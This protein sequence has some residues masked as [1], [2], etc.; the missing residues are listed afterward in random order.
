MQRKKEARPACGSG[1]GQKKTYSSTLIQGGACCKHIASRLYIKGFEP[2]PIAPGQK[3]PVSKNWP[4]MVLPVEPWPKNHGVGLRTGL[5][6]A[7]D[8]DIYH[9]GIID[10]LLTEQFTGLDYVTR[11]G[12]PPKILIPVVCPDLKCKIMSDRWIDEHGIINQIE[13]LSYGQQFVAFGIHPG[14]GKPY[15]WSDDFLKHTPPTVSLKFIGKLFALFKK[16]AK[17]SGWINVS[18][19]ARQDKNRPKSQTPSHGS[20]PGDIFNKA[21]TIEELLTVYGWKH[22]RGKWWTRPG[23][24]TGVSGTVANNTFYVFTSSTCLEPEKSY[25]C[26]G[27]LARYEFNG[28]FKAAARAVLKEMG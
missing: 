17:A 18:A 3:K 4:T 2:I 12:Q 25:D 27:L 15:L 13:V 20:R 5:L 19:R 23:K 9:E 26:F 24:R 7:I 21:C 8:M 28:D 16:V 22:Y 1:T 6:S 10:K 14:T 11:T